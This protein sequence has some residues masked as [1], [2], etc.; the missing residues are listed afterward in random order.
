MIRHSPKQGVSFSAI[1][2]FIVCL[3]LGSSRPICHHAGYGVADAYYYELDESVKTLAAATQAND[4]RRMEHAVLKRHEDIIEVGPGGQTPIMMATLLG[5]AEA[6]ETLIN[7]GADLSIP[8]V[9]GYSLVHGAS[10]QGHP[11]VLQILAEHG[12]DFETPH[13]DGYA[14]M[15]RACWGGDTRFTETVRVFLK[16]GIDPELPAK[17]GR[18]C[19]DMTENKYTQRLLEIALMEKKISVEPMEESNEEE[20]TQPDE[21]L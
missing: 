4:I 1:W 15:H 20:D 21:P 18:T 11:E 10:F 5:F 8:E 3:L 14:P 13:Q 12:M 7:L 17:D 2:L 9:H 6:V 16:L 19:F